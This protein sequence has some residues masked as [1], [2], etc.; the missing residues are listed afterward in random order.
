LNNNFESSKI[1]PKDKEILNVLKA[2]LSIGNNTDNTSS[3]NEM[4]NS[5]AIGSIFFRFSI[6]NSGAGV[7]SNI[8][9]GNNSDFLKNCLGTCPLNYAFRVNS[10]NEKENSSYLSNDINLKN[11][12]YVSETCLS[13]TALNNTFNIPSNTQSL[14]PIKPNWNFSSI[15]EQ[16]SKAFLT[17]SSLSNIRSGFCQTVI[18]INI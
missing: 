9:F 12:G 3:D 4:I 7:L 16:K 1:F 2:E 5:P 13:C 6:M 8:V 14:Y 15:Q 17:K 10:L 11:L 18:S